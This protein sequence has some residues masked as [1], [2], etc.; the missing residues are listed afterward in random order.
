MARV[1]G[2]CE[3]FAL[4]AAMNPCPCGFHGDPRRADGEQ[5]L[6]RIPASGRP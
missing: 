6:E 5:E 3:T 1:K 4:V 2:I